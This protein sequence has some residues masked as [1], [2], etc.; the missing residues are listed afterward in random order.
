MRQIFAVKK[1]KT[2]S[3]LVIYSCPEA[4]GRNYKKTTK[5]ILQSLGETCLKYSRS[6]N[7][8]PTN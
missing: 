2:E 3:I 1:N 6:C 8:L 5:W 7:A 4:M